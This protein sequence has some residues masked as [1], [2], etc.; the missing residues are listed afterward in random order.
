MEP[1]K[2]GTIVSNGMLLAADGSEGKPIFLTT[3]EEAPIGAAVH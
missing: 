3:S 2:I 1:R